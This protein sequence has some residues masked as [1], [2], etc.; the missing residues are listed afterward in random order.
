MFSRA[1]RQLPDVFAA[2]Q[3]IGPLDCVGLFVIGQ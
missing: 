1:S 3:M 2:S